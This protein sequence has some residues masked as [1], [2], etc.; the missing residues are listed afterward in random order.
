MEELVNLFHG[1]AVVIQ[2]GAILAVA[3]YLT[4]NRAARLI[5]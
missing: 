4:R 2:L 1:F 5:T 3:D